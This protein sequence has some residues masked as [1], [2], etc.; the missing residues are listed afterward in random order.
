VD[1]EQF[2]DKR[3]EHLARQ[4]RTRLVTVPLS[5][6]ID[7]A[8]LDE[9]VL[10]AYGIAASG[11]E[12]EEARESCRVTRHEGHDDCETSRH[13]WRGVCEGRDAEIGAPFNRAPRKKT[14]CEG[15]QYAR[16]KLR[17]GPMLLS[18]F[19]DFFE[20][21]SW[22]PSVARYLRD[23]IERDKGFVQLNG[24]QAQRAIIC[25]Y[26]GANFGRKLEKAEEVMAL[27]PRQGLG[28]GGWG[29]ERPR[30]PD[31]SKLKPIPPNWL[32]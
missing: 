31:W 1:V 9:V 13:F 10:Y 12:A 3:V 26:Q 2:N 7:E 5:C 22:Y 28:I 19:C 17:G 6:R 4:H 29:D 14:R 18:R 11:D 23:E 24:T 30:Q 20:L 21:Y 16:F 25:L 8:E 15:S 27:K 32:D